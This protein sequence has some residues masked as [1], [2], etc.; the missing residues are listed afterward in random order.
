MRPAAGTR[1]LSESF[2]I[3]DGTSPWGLWF[4]CRRT[5]PCTSWDVEPLMRLSPS[6]HERVPAR[7]LAHGVRALGRDS[8]DVSVI[9]AAIDAADHGVPP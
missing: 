6:V 7:P 1:H 9:R 5:N 8:L 3:S 4:L 2:T